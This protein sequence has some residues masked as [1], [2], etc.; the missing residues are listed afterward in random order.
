MNNEEIAAVLRAVAIIMAKH[1]GESDNLMVW[2]VVDKLAELARKR[3]DS[4]YVS[5]AR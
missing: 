3:E 2:D 4:I 5:G 1:L